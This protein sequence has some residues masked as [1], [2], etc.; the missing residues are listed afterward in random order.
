M[1]TTFINNLNYNLYKH[2]V[3]FFKVRRNKCFK[4]AKYFVHGTLNLWAA[5]VAQTENFS[6]FNFHS[7]SQEE[8]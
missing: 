5:F 1:C 6:K 3:F 8:N 4:K 2:N 7:N